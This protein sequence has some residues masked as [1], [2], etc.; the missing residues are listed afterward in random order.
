MRAKV[1]MHSNS[2]P[3]TQH[4]PSQHEVT[5]HRSLR[6]MLIKVFFPLIVAVMAL[7]ALPWGVL[8]SDRPKEH[9]GELTNRCGIW[10]GQWMMFAPKPSVN[11]LWL[12]A[13]VYDSGGNEVDFW[14]SP[15]W[16]DES[17]GAKFLR[18]RHMNYYNRLNLPQ[19]QVA[20][21]D[22]A[23]YLGRTLAEQKGA[24][25]PFGVELHSNK[26]QLISPKTSR[27]PRSDE[28]VW[29]TQSIFL[30]DTRGPEVGF[31][32]LKPLWPQEGTP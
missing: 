28:L 1:P 7:D 30:V 4:K 13:K 16:P 12:T 19:N 22:F 32:E 18:F 29:V 9:L 3:S 17:A 20:C 5:Q 8:P 14:T 15:Y 26:Y 31:L 24:S 11:N 27:L 25:D 2:Q 23:D 21:R 10:Q 6:K